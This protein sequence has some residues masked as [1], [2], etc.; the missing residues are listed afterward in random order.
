MIKVRLKHL[1]FD[2]SPEPINSA[3]ENG[4]LDNVSG[5]CWERRHFTEY[6]LQIFSMM[7]LCLISLLEH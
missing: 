2:G 3:G 1:R 4:G 5:K 7:R 6:E